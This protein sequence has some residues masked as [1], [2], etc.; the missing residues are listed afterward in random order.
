MS[1]TVH[2]EIKLKNKK[3]IGTLLSTWTKLYAYIKYM[4][5]NESKGKLT[6]FKN[7]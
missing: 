4:G 2:K 6:L 7:S 3:I 1:F 5:Q